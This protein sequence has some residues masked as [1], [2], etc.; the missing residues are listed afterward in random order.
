[1]HLVADHTSHTD[2][3]LR[4]RVYGPIPEGYEEFFVSETVKVETA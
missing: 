2:K 1:V 4:V 3:R